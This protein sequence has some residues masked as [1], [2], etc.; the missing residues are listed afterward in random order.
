MFSPSSLSMSCR[1][2][3]SAAIRH[4]RK[5][6]AIQKEA[7]ERRRANRPAPPQSKYM[8]EIFETLVIEIVVYKWIN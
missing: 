1:K 6:R 7:E 2:L 3:T 5:T 8:K 4:T